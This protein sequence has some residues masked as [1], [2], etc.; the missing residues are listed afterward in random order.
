MGTI[1]SKSKRGRSKF[2]LED[3]GIK[4]KKLSE[5]VPEKLLRKSEIG[6][7]DLNESLVVR[8]Y[9]NLARKNYGVDNGIYPLGSCTMKYNPK[10]NEEIAK[11]NCF[12][13]IHPYQDISDI[14]GSLAV[15]Y[16]LG[17]LLKQIIGLAGVTLQP[18][19]GAHGEL[20]GLLIAKK[21]FNNKKEDR[22]KVLIPDS[23]HGT[24]FASAAMAGY[25]VIEVK[26]NRSGTIDLESL[27]E[28]I[29]KESDSIALIMITNPNTLGI[30]ESD[31]LNISKIMH[32]N[33]SLLYYDGANLNAILGLARPGD[34]GFDI[35][36]LNLHKSFSTP[37]G[38]G[39]PGAGPVLV[40]KRLKGYLP[41]PVV[42]KDGKRYFLNYNVRNTIGKI[43]SFYGNFSVCLKAYCYLLSSGKELK[44]ISI[45][46]I[47]NANYLKK[48]LSKL[49]D[50]PYKKNIMH[51]FVMSAKKYKDKGGSALNIAKRLIDYGIHP[52]TIYFP[53]IVEEAMMIEP[54]ETENIESLD[55]LTEV[56]SK[57]V[58]EIE[59]NPEVL[60]NA[61]IGAGTKRVDELKAVK[62]PILKE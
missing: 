25:E 54:T 51:E 23:A 44:N 8:H 47:L 7:P 15:M 35:V 11:Y 57:I 56:F 61:P 60:K 1:F 27:K 20:C 59:R 43:K 19:A 2:S 17:E 37:H 58:K 30:F 46:A 12:T 50:I 55:N 48:K 52:P 29:I 5:L 14:Q 36:H 53:P 28:I 24:N 16:E 41:V 18:S 38:G 49:F 45:D 39:G 4:E 22:T 10:V 34:M 6:L 21:Y 3:I 9:T 32:D 40:T 62:K 26:S 42:G 13:D 31:I 33:G